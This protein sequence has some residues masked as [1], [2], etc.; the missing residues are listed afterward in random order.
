MNRKKGTAPVQDRRTKEEQ[1]RVDVLRMR[2]ARVPL[3]SIARAFNTTIGRIK[4]VLEQIAEDHALIDADKGVMVRQCELDRI[5]HDAGVLHA[6]ISD[7]TGQKA[8]I[9]RAVEAQAKLTMMRCKLL[10]LDKDESLG[11]LLGALGEVLKERP[12]R[13]VLVEEESVSAILGELTFDDD[14]N[15]GVADGGR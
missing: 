5:E 3:V 10:G 15:V 6:I 4:Q 12:K 13:A 1:R 7:P 11:D 9:I 2:I 14:D 8:T